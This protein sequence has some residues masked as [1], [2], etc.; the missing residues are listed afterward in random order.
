MRRSLPNRRGDYREYLD[1]NKAV[2]EINWKL[3][4]NQAEALLLWSGV[5][6]LAMRSR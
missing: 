1:L 2:T 4:L 6:H 3:R 5:H